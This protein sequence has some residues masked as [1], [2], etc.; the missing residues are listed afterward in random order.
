[1]SIVRQQAMV[2]LLKIP[3]GGPTLGEID[4]YELGYNSRDQ[5]VK[6]LVNGLELALAHLSGPSNEIS[7]E[8]YRTIKALITKYSK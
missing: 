3:N 4:A 7:G 5:E 6:E 2:E 1:M 8:E